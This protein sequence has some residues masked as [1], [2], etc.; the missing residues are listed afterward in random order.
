MDA[1]LKEAQTSSNLDGS[2]TLAM[3]IHL[4]RSQIPVFRFELGTHETRLHT[5]VLGTKRKNM[6][7][8]RLK[9]IPKAANFAKTLNPKPPAVKP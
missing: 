6:C 5:H 2:A 3:Q 8:Q 9:L 4:S 7:C 1:R